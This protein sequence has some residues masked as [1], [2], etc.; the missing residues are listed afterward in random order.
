MQGAYDLV[1]WHPIDLAIQFHNISTFP[2]IL[3][4]LINKPQSNVHIQ[5]PLPPA[6]LPK[7][8]PILLIDIINIP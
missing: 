2:D 7:S 5:I 6:P 1:K 3:P 8:P 4:I